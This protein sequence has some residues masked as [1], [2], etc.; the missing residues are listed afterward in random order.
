MWRVTYL[1]TVK[2]YSLFIADNIFIIIITTLSIIFKVYYMNLILIPI[3]NFSS[4]KNSEFLT[5]LSS[6]TFLPILIFICVFE[7]ILLNKVVFV[8]DLYSLL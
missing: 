5:P 2:L 8:A 6:N 4:M 7:L 1:L 3:T